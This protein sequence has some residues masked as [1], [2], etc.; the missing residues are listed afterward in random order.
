MKYTLKMLTTF[1]TTAPRNALHM[2]GSN[3]PEDTIISCKHPKFATT[4]YVTNHPQ[5]KKQQ[6]TFSGNINNAFKFA[7]NVA[8]NI[9]DEVLEHKTNVT[10]HRC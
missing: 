9:R 2:Q 5:G 6:P 3:Q 7:S 4:L 10:L 8:K 1:L